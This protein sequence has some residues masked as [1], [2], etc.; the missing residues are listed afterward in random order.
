MK[1]LFALLLLVMCIGHL[2]SE[3]LLVQTY[4]DDKGGFSGGG[5]DFADPSPPPPSPTTEE[6]FDPDYD[7]SFWTRYVR[8]L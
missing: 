8:R 2:K 1:N 3:F 5:Q 7:P 4:D 6:P